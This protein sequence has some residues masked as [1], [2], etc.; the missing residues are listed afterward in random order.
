M[1]AWLGRSIESALVPNSCV[2]CGGRR[3]IE[4]PPVCEPCCD[5]LPWTEPFFELPPFKCAAAP[6]EYAFPVDAAIRL[7]KFRRKLCYA[8]AFAHLLRGALC[9]MPTDVDAVLPVPL[10]WRRQ[11]LRGFNQA[12]EISRP[13]LKQLGLPFINNVSRYRATPYQSGLAAAHR[14]HNLRAAFRARGEITANHALL[15]DDVITTGATCRELA[16]LVLEAGV[17]QVSVLAIAR[18]GIH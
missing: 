15:V 9:G 7:F 1:L 8:P 6:L 3:R 18:S 13:L 17:E 10:H 4:E 14:R 5:D 11:T 12:T 16:R 2:F